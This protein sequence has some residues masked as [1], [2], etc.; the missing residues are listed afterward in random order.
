M[1]EQVPELGFA[2]EAINGVEGASSLIL[3]RRTDKM[4]D[5][6]A[7]ACMKQFM[8]ELQIYD[9][10][11]QWMSCLGKVPKEWINLLPEA[12]KVSDGKDYGR[13][14]IKENA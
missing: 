3:T 10:Y 9:K 12:I 8:E 14:I 5:E 7:V 6:E 11:Q 4:T 2:R 1:R 13:L